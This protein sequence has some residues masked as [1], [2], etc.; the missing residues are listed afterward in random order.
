MDK[1]EFNDLLKEMRE[2]L[3]NV[4]VDMNKQALLN[5]RDY[6]EAYYR[7]MTDTLMVFKEML[8]GLGVR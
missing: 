1:V 7:G 3:L 4:L 6:Y 2:C 8:N 5:G